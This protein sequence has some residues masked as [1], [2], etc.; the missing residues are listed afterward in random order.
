[1]NIKKETIVVFPHEV[2]T[3]TDGRH[4]NKIKIPF[5]ICT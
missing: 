4:L 2:M 1:M 5:I 3:I